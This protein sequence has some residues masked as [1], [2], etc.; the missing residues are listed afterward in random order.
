M[1]KVLIYS[2]ICILIKLLH[3]HEYTKNIFMECLTESIVTK[4]DIFDDINFIS[5][6]LEIDMRT[7]IKYP[8]KTRD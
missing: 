2:Q 5:D 6:L 3:S 8:D 7:V 1:P 4:I